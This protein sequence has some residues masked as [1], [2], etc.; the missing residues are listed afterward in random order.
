MSLKFF[1]IFFI[2]CS[3]LL[4]VGIGAWGLLSFG[5]TGHLLDVL[6]GGGSIL[7]GIGLAVYGVSFLR[8]MRHVGFMTVLL[9]L[10]PRVTMACPVCFGGDPNSPQLRGAQAAVFF[11]LAVTGVVLGGFVALF[12]YFWKRSRRVELE[13]AH[14][15]RQM[16]EASQ[17]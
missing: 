12:V 6:W 8:K 14:L 13:H 1:H 11:L 15:V 9:L 4:A 3:A 2:A 7:A 16:M 5:R 10:A 17:K